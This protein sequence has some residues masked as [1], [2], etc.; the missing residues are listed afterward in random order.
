[1]AATTLSVAALFNP[2]RKRIQGVVDRRFNR[3]MYDAERVADEF[4]GT[5]RDRV[6]PERVVDGWVGVVSE[7]LQPAAVG[8]WVRDSE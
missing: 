8:V 7:T 1:V 2:L 3:S 5:L 6:D 4:A